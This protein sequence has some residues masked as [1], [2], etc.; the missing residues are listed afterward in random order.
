MTDVMQTENSIQPVDIATM[1]Q[2]I[3][4]LLP[5]DA[6]PAGI[7]EVETLTNLLRDHMQLIIPEI[8]QAAGKLP[9][10]DVPRYCALACIGEA[11]AKLRTA[12]GHGPHRAV[13]YARKLARSLAA[14]CDHY[15]ALTGVEMCLAC[16]QPIRDRADSVAY[17]QV[18]ASG[19]ATSAG[20]IHTRCAHTGRRR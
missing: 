8:E 20:H 1:R 15:E 4:Q 3:G 11:R 14:L 19:G 17:G 18:S 5:P 2:T 9:T 10:D 7:S 13:A 16:D 6:K 12:A